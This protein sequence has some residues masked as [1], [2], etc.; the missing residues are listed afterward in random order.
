MRDFHIS[1]ICAAL[2]FA[3]PAAAKDLDPDQRSRVISACAAD[4]MRLCP[5]S[6]TSQNE[7]V[8]CMMKQRRQLGPACRSAYDQVVRVLAQK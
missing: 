4:A 6:L 8:S 5:Q 3:A 2:A 1:F 7:A